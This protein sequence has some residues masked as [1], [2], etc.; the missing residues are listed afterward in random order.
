MLILYSTDVPHLRCFMYNNCTDGGLIERKV[1]PRTKFHTSS[2]YPAALTCKFRLFLAK[3][4][5]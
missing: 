2:N 1:S 3:S 5:S 4:C